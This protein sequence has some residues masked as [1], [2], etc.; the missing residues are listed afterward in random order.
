MKTVFAFTPSHKLD[1]TIAIA[2]ARAGGIGVLDLGY[3][4]D[5][6]GIHNEIERL[7]DALTGAHAWGVRWIRL[8]CPVRSLDQLARL[9]PFKLPYW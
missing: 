3:R 7:R 2:G 1:A 5:I 9:L 6:S 4:L 8:V